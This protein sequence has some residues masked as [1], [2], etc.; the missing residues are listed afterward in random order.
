MGQTFVYRHG[1]LVFHDVF[2][3]LFIAVLSGQKHNIVAFVCRFDRL[4]HSC[5]RGI[6]GA[7]HSVKPRPV[8]IIIRQKI[9][10]PLVRVFRFPLECLRFGISGLPGR[11]DKRPLVY[12]GL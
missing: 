11:H 5:R 10:H 12:I 3:I 1:L 2:Q 4:R 7:K 6:V 9:H 8:G